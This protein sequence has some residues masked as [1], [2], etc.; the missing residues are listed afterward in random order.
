MDTLALPLNVSWRTALRYLVMIIVA[1]VMLMPMAWMFISSIRPASSIFQYTSIL[2]WRS[3]F[4]EVITLDNYREVFRSDFPRAIY[5]SLFIGIV[6][7]AA[8]IFVNSAAGFAFAVFDF[9]FK[10][11]LF[12]L[13]MV[14]FMVPFESI[15]IP[16]YQLIRTLGWVNSYQA[17]IV[18]AIANGFVI[19][20]FRQ[21]VAALPKELYEAARV[22]GATWWQIYWRIVLPLSFPTIVTAALM[23]F[24]LQWESF[25]WPLVAASGDDY[26]VVQVALARHTTA[27]HTAWGRLFGSLSITVLIPMALYLL[28]QRFYIRTIAGSGLK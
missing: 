14:T 26:T 23:M 24:I 20:L 7:V 1:V 28:A 17:L 27:E 25:F 13:V 3:I 21:F 12:L 19:F 15:V 8:G 18:P 9:P 10:R 4:P 6:T 11:T 16:L 5:N 2:S 22:D